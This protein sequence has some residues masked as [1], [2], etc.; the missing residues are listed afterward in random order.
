PLAYETHYTAKISAEV[1]DL[2]GNPMQADYLW[3]FTTQSAPLP[4]YCATKGK[5]ASY[6]WI[7]QIQV[8]SVSKKTGRNNGYADFTGDP[9]PLNAGLNSIVLTPGFSSGSYLEYWKIWVDMNHNYAF[10]ENEV[11]FSGNSQGGLN[12]NFTIPSIALSG[13][14]RMRITMKYAGAPSACEIFSYGEVED[15]TVQI[16]ATDTV[17]PEIESVYPLPDQNSAAVDVSLIVVFSEEIDPTT[18]TNGTF[19]LS[20]GS[21]NVAGT[22]V[23]SGV[24]AIFTPATP[25]LNNTTYSATLTTG[26]KDL[27]GNNLQ[28]NYNWFFTTEPQSDFIP[29]QVVSMTPG[30]NSSGVS[31]YAVISAVFSESIKMDSINAGT[32]LVND[33]SGNMA[34]TFQGNGNTI[35]F[36][37]AT[38]LAY[39]TI[40]TV[41]LNTGITDLAGNHMTMDF[42]WSFLTEPTPVIHNVTVFPAIA[43]N[44]IDGGAEYGWVVDGIMDKIYLRDEYAEHVHVAKYESL[45]FTQ[46]VDW[47]GLYEFKLPDELSGANIAIDEVKLYLDIE[48][49][50]SG[51]GEILFG[52]Y[53]GNGIAELSDFVSE[54]PISSK[55]SPSTSVTV[56]VTGFVKPL[57]SSSSYAG[58]IIK[59]ASWVDNHWVTFWN[60]LPHPVYGHISGQL[61]YLNIKYHIVQ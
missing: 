4:Q 7:E 25:L 37:P 11:V 55:A 43:A 33:G 60:G 53:Q 10:E 44:A 22:I 38:A 21:T 36:I 27:A 47:R 19:F 58:F 12:G 31:A 59:T 18:I 46:H 51:I 2:A 23:Q 24:T 57:C 56:D 9:I 34:G 42:Q 5:N 26:V 1:R 61:I 40:Y 39:N 13:N 30:D 48:G 35:H 8:N 3:G 17:P 20:D 6:E 28:T 32:F 41:I 54:Q 29:P 15:Y 52:G 49:N 45:D 16:P 14:T 50:P